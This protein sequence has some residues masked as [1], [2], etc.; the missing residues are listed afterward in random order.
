VPPFSNCLAFFFV[1]HF[2]RHQIIPIQRVKGNAIRWP[3]LD[4]ASAMHPLPA[5]PTGRSGIETSALDRSEDA[6]DG[7]SM[8]DSSTADLAAHAAPGPYSAPPVDPQQY[9]DDPAHADGAYGAQSG[10]GPYYDPYRGP[11]PASLTP[12]PEEDP[13]GGTTDPYGR[14]GSPGPQAAYDTTQHVEM[15][16]VGGYDAFGAAAPVGGRTPSPGPN[17][18][19]GG[20]TSPGPQVAYGGGRSGSPGPEAAYGTGRSGSPGPQVAYGGGR[21]GSPGPEAA[22][23]TGRSRSPGPQVAYGGAHTV[24]A[25]PDGA[26][27]GYR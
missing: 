25:G 9:Y 17:A 7:R 5:R 21:G 12:H 14:T 4:G 27:G 20:R 24:P 3:E 19:Y 15:Q 13:Y 22:Y 23:G 6:F 8:A 26:D 16:H 18:A 2:A 1:Q 10:G 11:V